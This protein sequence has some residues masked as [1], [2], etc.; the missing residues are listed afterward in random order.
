[1]SFPGEFQLELV[2]S[3]S[4]G[5]FAYSRHALHSK[6]LGAPVRFGILRPE[7]SSLALRETVYLFHGGNGDDRQPIDLGFPDILEKTL[8]SRRPEHLAPQFVFPFI[9]TSF[10]HAHPTDSRRSFSDFFFRELLPCVEHS[11]ERKEHAR[12]LVG[13]S[14]G[15]QAALNTFL[16]FP[17]MFQGVGAHF[18]TLIRFRYDDEEDVRQFV[19]RT[20]IGRESLEILISGFK[21]EF[22]DWG[23]FSRHDPI[24]LLQSKGAD[25]FVG[26]RIYFDVGTDDEFG[27]CEGGEYF[28]Q[29]LQSKGLGHGFEK[30]HGGKHDAA[31]LWRQF[32]KLLEALFP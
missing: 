14:M 25:P 18:P 32:P 10:L 2:E 17:E 15:G 27:L 6:V 7:G 28:H 26:K 9:G 12:Y 16:R 5:A 22:A 24:S 30:V 23:D 29:L 4:F 11:V 19:S 13:Y 1:M 8:L 31:F 20:S 3:E 21:N